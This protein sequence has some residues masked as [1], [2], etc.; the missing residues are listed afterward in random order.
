MKKELVLVSIK[1][2][3]KASLKSFDC[4][5]SV[6]NEFLSRYAA[7]NDTLGIGKTFVAL[8]D[9]KNIVGYF[10]LATAQIAFEK[11]PE[12]SKT[13]LPK[14]PI[15]ALRIARLAVN[16]SVQ[17]KGVGKW[18]L[19]QAFIKAV[20]VSDVAGLYFVI[21]DA[22]ETSKSFYERYGFK[23]IP[24]AS[25]TYLLSIETIKAAIQSAS[26][27]PNGVSA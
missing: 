20:Q 5:V 27:T 15:P 6:L 3:Q 2:V 22:K 19:S 16:Q 10:T 21:V 25:L 26:I 4:G 9:D 1:K 13:K 7:K 11:I 8:N 17:G 18:L 24:D 14:Y 12:D 23:K